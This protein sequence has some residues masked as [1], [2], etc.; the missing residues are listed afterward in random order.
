MIEK[1]KN[2]LGGTGIIIGF[3]ALLLIPFFLLNWYEG[4]FNTIYPWIV[5]IT[6]FAIWII[7]LSF[8]ISVFP[9]ARYITGMIMVIFSWAL[10]LMLWLVNLYVSGATLGNVWTIFG[11]AFMG[12]G[13][14]ITSGIGML[15]NGN[16]FDL[17]MML[18]Y[19]ALI[20]GVRM[21]GLFV[22]SKYPEP[23][24]GLQN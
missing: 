24:I 23:K 19:L 12:I 15:I 11:V 20:Y 6:G 4:I 22:S 18:I 10:G 21:L 3:I 2:L 14:F 7:V 9:K 1:I 17:F 16:F 5:K 13:V 8:L